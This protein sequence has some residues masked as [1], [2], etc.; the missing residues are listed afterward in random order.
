MQFDNITPGDVM[1]P[2]IRSSILYDLCNSGSYQEI[3][4]FQYFMHLGA[5]KMACFRCVWSHW[6]FIYNPHVIFLYKE[7]GFL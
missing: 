1:S 2:K 3:P 4:I 7:Y 5:R 6:I